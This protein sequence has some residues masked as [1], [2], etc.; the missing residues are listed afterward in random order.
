MPCIL[1][2]NSLEVHF[3]LPLEGYNF[4]RFDWTGKITEISFKNV[5]VTTTERTDKVNPNHF[6]RGLYNEFGIE[7]ALGFEEARPGEWFHKIGVGA[8]QKTDAPYLFSA[9]YKIRPTQFEV[10]REANKLIVVCHSESLNGYAYELKKEISLQEIS[11]TIQYQLN[12]TGQKPITTDEYVHNF[13]GINQDLIGKEYEL[14]FPFELDQDAFDM[15]V[16]PEGKM[17]FGKR[18][19]SFN[20]TPQEQ[21][22]V[23]HLNGTQK[24]P[25][26]WELLHL[27]SKIGIRETGSFSTQKVNLWGWKHVVSP[28]LFHQISVQPGDTS[29]WSRTYECFEL[30]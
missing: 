21:F 13:M 26:L 1:K 16:N 8:L 4:S 20:A 15:L 17:G 27:K 6:G 11:L 29:K 12:N 19:V 30:E 18:E 3:D 22:F 24:V 5:P 25:A 14:R 28:E 2:N 10:T 7:T 23:S 9:P